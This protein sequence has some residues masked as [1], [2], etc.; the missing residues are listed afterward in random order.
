[1]FK[2]RLTPGKFILDLKKWDL[3]G[4]RLNARI[5]KAFI[6]MTLMLA[7]NLEAAD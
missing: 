5:T 2:T 7:Q 1:M 4:L 6:F 3:P